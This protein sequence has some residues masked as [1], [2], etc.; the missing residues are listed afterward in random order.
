MENLRERNVVT[1]FLKSGSE[2][3]IL[4]RSEQVGTYQGKW[5]GVSGY[6]DWRQWLY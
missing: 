2:I 3:L 4:R 1:C 5:A 6:I